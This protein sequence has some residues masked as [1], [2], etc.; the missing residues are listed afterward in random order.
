MILPAGTSGSI[1]L[2]GI[3]G[4]KGQYIGKCTLNG[5][6]PAGWTVTGASWV[7]LTAT[8]GSA[9]AGRFVLETPNSTFVDSGTF[10]NSGTFEDDSQG[11]VQTILVTDFVNTGTVLA[12]SGGFGTAGVAYNPSCPKCTF[13]DQGALVVNPKQSFSSGSTFVL[14]PS[15]TIADHGLF[16]LANESTFYVEGG[17]V[18]AGAPTSTQ[19]LGLAAPTVKFA[20]DVPPTSHGRIDITNSANLVGVI[21]KHWE[22]DVTGGSV[23]ASHA[24]NAGTFYWDHTDNSSLTDATTFINSGTFSDSTTGWVQD[25]EVSRFVNT[26]TVTSDAP[27]FGMSGAPGISGPVFVNDGQ[28]V[29]EPKANFQTAGTFDLASGT[30]VNHG[31]LGID[32]STLE[33]G[34]GS[35]L[36]TPANVNYYLG[37]GPATVTFEPS[38]PD[39]SIGSVDFGIGLT[40]NGVIP[41]G[42]VIDNVGGIGPALTVNHSGNRGT[43]IWATRA[44]FTAASPFTNEGT[45]KAFGTLEMSGQTSSTPHRQG[46]ARQR[47]RLLD[48]G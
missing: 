21:A 14:A 39:S 45:I 2:G 42:W 34:G 12:A 9:N 27:G 18:T 35:L 3:D 28:F 38:V 32:K 8:P 10:T 22:L 19:Y 15:G 13:L 37:A 46:L 20:P 47:R 48:F 6:I 29:I 25:I 16:G 4:R 5:A 1:L 17:A 43:I 24:G 36:G 41:Q 44:P 30:I 31:N 33:V 26:G 11:L 40:V 7:D 23:A